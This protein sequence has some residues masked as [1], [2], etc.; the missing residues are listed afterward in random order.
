M[1]ARLWLAGLTVVG[2]GVVLSAR[3]AVIPVEAVAGGDQGAAA[4]QVSGRWTAKTQP[5]WKGND[6]VPR[7]QLSLRTGDDRDHWGFGVPV[8]ELTD[9]PGAAREGTVTEARF[10]LTREAGTFRF[11]G[12]FDRGQGAGT[13]AFLPSSAYVTGIAQLGYRNLVKEQLMRLAVLDV[14]SAFARDLRDAGQA[15]LA[16]DD[17]TRM[18]IHGA[19]G[20]VVRGF[21]RPGSARSRQT[22]SCGSESTVSRRSSSQD[23]HRATTPASPPTTTP[24]CVSTA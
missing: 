4:G 13:F 7:L 17:L 12:P 1:R 9:L 11:T 10:T 23:S 2:V 5:G 22:T 8:A 15:N 16:L 21:K 3:G 6:V 14:T 24:A 18:K 20:A 19:T